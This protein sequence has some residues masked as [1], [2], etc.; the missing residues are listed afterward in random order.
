VASA[1]AKTSSPRKEELLESAYRYVLRHGLSSMSLRPLAAAIGTSPRVLMFLFGSK[2]Q[3]VR[4]LLARARRDELALLE[5]VGGQPADAG[6]ADV[7]ARLWDWLCQ[8]ENRELLTLWVDAY[9]RSLTEPDGPWAGFAE[10]TVQDWLTI[11]GRAGGADR[12]TATAVLAVLRGALLDLL[13]TSDVA[14]TTHAVRSALDR[15][16]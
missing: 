7:A 13:A 1:Q 3:L 5:P 2:E 11:L 14:R 9:A 15:F 10:D 4:E 8:T 6:L 16:A 12:T